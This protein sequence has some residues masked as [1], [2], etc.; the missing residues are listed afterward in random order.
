M[1]VLASKSEATLSGS[2]VSL[3]SESS[4]GKSFGVSA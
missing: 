2:S 3:T 4:P 1:L